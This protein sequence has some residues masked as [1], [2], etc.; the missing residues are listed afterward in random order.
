VV[1]PIAVAVAVAVAALPVAIACV[2]LWASLAPSSS[3]FPRS[4]PLRCPRWSLR[5]APL[6]LRCPSRCLL[7]PPA[8]TAAFVAAVA[9]CCCLSVVPA[10]ACARPLT[11]SPSVVLGFCLSVLGVWL[12]GSP[13]LRWPWAFKR[14]KLQRFYMGQGILV[15]RRI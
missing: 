11:A 8:L 7:P 3:P 6:V 4:S 5:L 10:S 12:A 15:K 13:G 14:R 2:C 1:S 9:L